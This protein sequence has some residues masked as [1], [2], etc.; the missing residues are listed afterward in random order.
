[1]ILIKFEEEEDENSP[2]FKKLK[3][4]ARI[5]IQYR[6]I[7]PSTQSN[8]APMTPM[9]PASIPAFIEEPRIAPLDEE[10]DEE[11]EVLVPVLEP[12]DDVVL[13]V[14]PVVEEVLDEEDV[15]EVDDVPVA[16]P[17]EDVPV[18]VVPEVPVLVEPDEVPEALE[19]LKQLESEL[20]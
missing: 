20:L 11:D 12:V 3:G 13:D 8:A 19:E 16:V 18:A 2:E 7:K 5:K 15:P 4:K 17:V 9:T 1:M 14:V 10:E 6:F